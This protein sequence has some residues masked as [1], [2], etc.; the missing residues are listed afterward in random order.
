MTKI[1]VPGTVRIRGEKEEEPS[2]RAGRS[3]KGGRRIK[4]EDDQERVVF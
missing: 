4:P 1:W 2:K 3:D